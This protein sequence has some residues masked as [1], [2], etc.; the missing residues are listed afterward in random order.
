MK[1]RADAACRR[2]S[3]PSQPVSAPTIVAEGRHPRLSA[4]RVVRVRVGGRR[5][6][7]AHERVHKALCSR[8]AVHALHVRLPTTS[9]GVLLER[10]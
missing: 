6:F 7:L 4:R 8:G 5:G 10:G 1:T 3:Q 9:V 2:N